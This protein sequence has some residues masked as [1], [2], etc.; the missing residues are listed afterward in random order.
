VE[1]PTTTEEHVRLML[2][3]D[4]WRSTKERTLD[5]HILMFERAWCSGGFPLSGGVTVC[6]RDF[7]PLNNPR[8]AAVRG[9]QS[10]ARG[11]VQ[12]TF[13]ANCAI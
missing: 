3:L 11:P 5:H 13:S 2:D 10:L 6:I 1:S 9:D 4:R 12:D 8:K 7:A